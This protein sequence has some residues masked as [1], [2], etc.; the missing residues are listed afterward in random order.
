MGR[1]DAVRRLDTDARAKDY[2][3]S[4]SYIDRLALVDGDV[5]TNCEGPDD[6]A[7]LKPSR[8]DSCCCISIVR[9]LDPHVSTA[10]FAVVQHVNV[11]L[12][13]AIRAQSVLAVN[14]AAVVPPRRTITRR[15]IVG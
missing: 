11:A 3:A 7:G 1:R 5:P 13:F 8:M 6:D 14:R 10:Q 15:R 12:F 4:M 9:N 2:K